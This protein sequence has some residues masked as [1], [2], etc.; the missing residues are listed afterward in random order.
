MESEIEAMIARENDE[1]VG[2][3]LRKYAVGRSSYS[4]SSSDEQSTFKK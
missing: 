2:N 4:Y 3:G 1:R